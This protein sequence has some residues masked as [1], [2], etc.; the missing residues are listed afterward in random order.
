M[1]GIRLRQVSCRTRIQSNSLDVACPVGHLAKPDARPFI[2]G[3]T[4]THAQWF[5]FATSRLHPHEEARL[6]ARRLLDNAT[7]IQFAHLMAPDD[8]LNPEIEREL[9]AR[10]A[11]LEEGEPLPYVLGLAPFF[12]RDW[13]VERG[14]LIPRPETELLVEAVLE[15]LQKPSA[16]VAELGTGSGIIAGTLALERPKWNVWATELSPGARVVA[17]R[18][19][20]QLNAR[21]ELIQ[22][23]ENDWLSP[24]EHLAPLDC[25][26]SNPP[27][28]ASTE[29]EKLQGSVRDFEPRLALDGGQDGLNPYREIAANGRELLSEGGFVA[30]EVGWDQKQR[31]EELFADWSR[32][33]W[34]WDFQGIARTAVVW[35]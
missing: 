35:K 26:A 32:L 14:V 22:G 23:R 13:Q 30:I 5:H 34:K 2:S 4:K 6:L 17:L 9:Q 29:I 33:G 27:Y 12:G 16:R 24:I 21:V 25:I 31:I 11:R 1:S 20:N 10:L 19:F 3:H 28:I 15:H 18:N 8:E 7:T